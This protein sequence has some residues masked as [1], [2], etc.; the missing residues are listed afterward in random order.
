MKLRILF[1]LLIVTLSVASFNRTFS[2]ITMPTNFKADVVSTCVREAMRG[3]GIIELSSIDVDQCYPTWA[4][5]I[6][7]GVSR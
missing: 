3:K 7:Y 1:I 6:K 2:D 5:S 4:L